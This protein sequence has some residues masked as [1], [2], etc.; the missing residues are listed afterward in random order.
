MGT[1]ESILLDTEEAVVDATVEA[2]NTRPSPHLYPQQQQ[3][4]AASSSSPPTIN[5]HRPLSQSSASARAVGQQPQ[6]QDHSNYVPRRAN[7]FQLNGI[8]L[9]LSNSGKRTLLQR[10]EGKE[11]EFKVST[12][13]TSITTGDVNSMTQ[14]DETET[15]TIIARY[16]APPHLPSFDTNIQLHVHASRKI[17]DKTIDYD[18]FV[19]LVNPRY[20]RIKIRKYLSKRLH[21]ILRIQG[22]DRAKSSSLQ[23]DRRKPL[24]LML[25]RN[26]QD[27]IHNVEDN[28]TVTSIAD[29]TMW[30]MEVL[31]DFSNIETPP[32]LQ[33][34]DTSLL[35]CYGL[36][37]LHHF[38]YQAYL[39]RKRYDLQQE[40]YNVDV[41]VSQSSQEA[42]T[43]VVP[44]D[45]YV[46]QVERL[47]KHSTTSHTSQTP[48]MSSNSSNSA[49][50]YR[51]GRNDDE[52]ATT[53]TSSGAGDG[54]RRIVLPY[55]QQ[56]NRD[57]QQSRVRTMSGGSSSTLPS[58]QQSIDNA[59]DALEAFLESDDS[60]EGN[61]D[62]VPIARRQ[63]KRTSDDDDDDDSDDDFYFDESGNRINNEISNKVV[64][65]ETENHNST[66]K[67]EQK[68]NVVATDDTL[69]NPTDQLSRI[70]HKENDLM[71]SAN[72]V[73]N[74]L[75]K[76]VLPVKINDEKSPHD[77]TL[78]AC[79]N[80]ETTSNPSKSNSTKS[81]LA[82]NDDTGVDVVSD[83]PHEKLFVDIGHDDE[84]DSDF[85]VDDESD[86]T[87]FAVK[88]NESEMVVADK[89][90]DKS[91][92]KNE[93]RNEIVSDPK[94]YVDIE[95][96]VVLPEL[97]H[98]EITVTGM[99]QDTVADAS[100]VPPN[101]QLSDAARA[102]IA[103][104]QQDFERMILH[105]ETLET[106]QLRL[107]KKKK[108]EKKSTSTKKE[109]KNKRKPISY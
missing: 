21:D 52:T 86:Q 80:V 13:R 31:Q 79:T 36:S 62:P 48:V 35:N 68:A 106:E 64:V 51:T 81:K 20:D 55:A 14:E 56:Q 50:R 83:K 11:P 47:L 8:V 58:A 84:N 59:K 16:Q 57:E 87:N 6:H 43:L 17:I 12:S 102:A 53:A 104:A 71:Q 25:L 89:N 77:E 5:R 73:A 27:M 9:G 22:C 103:M 45:E 99:T 96:P 44:Y 65:L 70:N 76:E 82:Y 33:C 95:R 100:E 7:Q 85:F 61:E 97:V 28:T 54:R 60:D 46:S 105:D 10:L 26:F 69:G 88:K 93:N 24:C 94:S 19:I 72:D 42:S 66:T 40:L 2:V 74:K 92:D 3:R 75:P 23:H 38:I 34:S 78:I 49:G 39:Q 37:T 91:L 107:K 67:T 101:S 29:M 30:T 18:F 98:G 109:K 15:H 41:A 1:T 108:D 32:L 63:S 90:S 4:T